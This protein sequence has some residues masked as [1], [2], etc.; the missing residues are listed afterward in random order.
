MVIVSTED[1]ALFWYFGRKKISSNHLSLREW[2]LGN[3]EIWYVLMN[4][5]VGI[6]FFLNLTNSG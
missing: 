2:N 6:I 3:L 1:G 4:L 5:D